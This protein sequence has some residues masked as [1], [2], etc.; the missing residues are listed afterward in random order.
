MSDCCATEPRAVLTHA[1]VKCLEC[2]ETGRPVPTITLKQMVQPHLLEAVSKPGFRFCRS[3]DC[4]VVYFHP[5]GE[6]LRKG[7]LRVRVGVK[8]TEDPVPLCYCFGFTK[9]MAVE[10]IQA[11]GGCTIPARIAA[12]VKAGN[13]A[14]EARNPQGSCCLGQVAAVIKRLASVSAPNRQVPLSILRHADKP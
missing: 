1:V 8:E 4:D 6:Q 5:D 2:G 3:P 13:C 10:E 14:C 11:T 7:D 12:E 9:A